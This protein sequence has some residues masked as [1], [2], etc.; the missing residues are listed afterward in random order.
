M[1][2]TLLDPT[3][4]ETEKSLNALMDME[5]TEDLFGPDLA[6]EIRAIFCESLGGNLRNDVAH[7]LLDDQESQSYWAV[8]AWWLALKLVFGTYRDALI[9]SKQRAGSNPESVVADDEPSSE[10]V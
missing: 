6:F 3:G 5:E 10:G 7:G 2:T 8:Y 4:V 1:V 9:A